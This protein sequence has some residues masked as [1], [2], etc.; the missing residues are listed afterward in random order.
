[1]TEKYNFSVHSPN[2][3]EKY[4]FFLWVHLCNSDGT[5]PTE[6]DFSVGFFFFLWGIMHRNFIFNLAKHNFSV[7]VTPTEKLFLTANAQN[8]RIFLSS[9]FCG[10]TVRKIFIPIEKYPQKYDDRK[11]LLF[12]AFAVRN[13]FSVGVTRTEKLR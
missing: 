11:I 5:T 1:M 10:Y 3:T 9:Y 2:P 4:N 6:N 12:C 8:N 13:N 7:R